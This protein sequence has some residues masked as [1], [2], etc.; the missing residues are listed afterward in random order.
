MTMCIRTCAIPSTAEAHIL[1]LTTAVLTLPDNN[2]AESEYMQK[3]W[4]VDGN[5]L[6]MMMGGNNE[7]QEC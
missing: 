7:I 6:R 2:R 5:R 3:E 1:P 4:T